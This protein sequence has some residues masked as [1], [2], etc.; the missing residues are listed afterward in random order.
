[1]R[2]KIAFFEIEPWE[3]KFISE[4]LNKNLQFAF[5]V[6]PLTTDNVEIAV[7]YDIISPFIYSELNR[8]VIDQLPNLRL[9]AT[10]STGFDHIDLEACKERNITISNV[11]SYGENT[12]AEHTFSLILALSRK[13]LPSIERTRRGNFSLEGLRGFDLKDKTIGVIGAGHIGQHVIRIARGF[14]MNVVVFD[15]RQDELLAKSLGFK[16]LA[17]DE[18]LRTSDIITLHAPYNPHT[19]H[20]ISKKNVHEIKRGAI[21]INTSRGGLIE[22]AALV[23]GLNE[24]ILSGIG[25]DVLEEEGLIKE[26]RQLLSHEF[27]PEQLRIALETY[28]LLFRDNVII[29]PHNAFNSA[30]SVQRILETTITNI[31]S[32]IEGHPLNIVAPKAA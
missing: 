2:A 5:F 29:T 23:E 21:L 9:I 26:E 27:H 1:M 16:Y 28:A 30:E 4:H 14:E 15:V 13:L 31:K 12:V 18:L 6:D 19:H 17:L 20:M 24:G 32:F 22:T 8:D 25:L 11:P 7:G 10:R 3:E